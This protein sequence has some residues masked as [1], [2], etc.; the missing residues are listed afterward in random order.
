MKNEKIDALLDD[1]RET[2]ESLPDDGKEHRVEIQVGPHNSGYV[3]GGDQYIL[4]VGPDEPTRPEA[5]RIC[6]QCQRSTWRDTRECVHCHLDLF[7]H[8]HA[9]WRAKE[10]RRAQRSMIICIALGLAVIFFGQF[11]PKG[12]AGWAALGGFAFLF[13]GA[14]MGKPAGDA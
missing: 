3:A 9:V 1:L 8:D 13:A 11:L 5:S 10:R 14:V 2:L 6:P 4:R 12:M 7:A